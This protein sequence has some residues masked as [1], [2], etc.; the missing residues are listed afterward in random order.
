MPNIAIIPA[1]AAVAQRGQPARAPLLQPDPARSIEAL[2]LEFDRPAG[3]I[4]QLYADEVERLGHDARVRTF[5]PILAARSLR[6]RL[7][8]VDDPGYIGIRP[9]DPA[10]ASQAGLR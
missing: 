6:E 1:E 10:P 7:R 9:R 4:A 3:E 8:Q 5:L 2:A